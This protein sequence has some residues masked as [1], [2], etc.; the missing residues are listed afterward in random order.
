MIIEELVT[1]KQLIV[2][3]FRVTMKQLPG[4]KLMIYDSGI[5]HL[6]STEITQKVAAICSDC[7]TIE[8]AMKLLHR[9]N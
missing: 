7:S 2:D 3:G 1:K 6:N 4:K 5:S 8:D 9:S